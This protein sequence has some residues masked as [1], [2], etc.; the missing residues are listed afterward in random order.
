MSSIGVSLNE[1][2]RPSRHVLSYG[3]GPMCDR[4]SILVQSI[5]AVHMRHA[6]S[7]RRLQLLAEIAR[8]GLG[9][10][11]VVREVEGM[12]GLPKDKPLFDQLE[13]Y[14]KEQSPDFFDLHAL[15]TVRLW[16]ILEAFVH[17]ICCLLLAKVP[18]VREQE[19]VAKLKAP[20]IKLLSSG[21]Q[22]QAEY[23]Y[24]LIDSACSA[25]LKPGVGRFEAVLNALGFGGPVNGRVR[26]TLY[27]CSKLRNC[28]VHNDGIVDKQLVDACPWWRGT[29]GTRVGITAVMSQKH[30]FAVCWYMMEVQRRVLPGNFGGMA[31]LIE[32]QDSC[33]ESIEKG[34]RPG[35]FPF[36]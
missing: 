16:S 8:L 5:G 35:Q 20:V 21:E 34:G 26:D 6:A 7:I 15:V 29:E 28:I 13:T 27:H 18:S 14:A 2:S 33:V 11:Q 19:A 1:A 31:K 32:E 25:A 12:Q 23:L 36:A 22:E 4:P 30:L 17:D 9:Y 24:Q 10:A 3:I